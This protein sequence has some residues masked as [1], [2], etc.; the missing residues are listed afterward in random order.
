MTPKAINANAQ[1]TKTLQISEV[2]DQRAARM[3][4]RLLNL[5]RSLQRAREREEEVSRLRV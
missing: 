3:S 4:C 1:R 5:L 2:L